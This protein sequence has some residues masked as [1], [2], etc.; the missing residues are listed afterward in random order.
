M[1]YLEKCI[2]YKHKDVRLKNKYIALHIMLIELKN[3]ISSKNN[4]GYK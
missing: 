1:I 4:A 3:D 2:F